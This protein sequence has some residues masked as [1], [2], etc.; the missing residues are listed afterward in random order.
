VIEQLLRLLHHCGMPRTDADLI[1]GNGRVVNELLLRAQPR[2]TLF[3]GSQRVAEKLAV[4]MRGKVGDS[5]HCTLHRA[6]P[7]SYV[8]ALPA[9]LC[10]VR[11]SLTRAYKFVTCNTIHSVCSGDEQRKTEGR[12]LLMLCRRTLFWH[13]SKGG[14]LASTGKC[15][16][17]ARGLDVSLIIACYDC[18]TPSLE[19]LLAMTGTILLHAHQLQRPLI[20]A[21]YGCLGRLVK[22]S[23]RSLHAAAGFL[24]G[25]WL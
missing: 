22:Q 25:C 3:T 14:T 4:D 12:A 21:T 18:R 8:L 7:R 19:E 13:V 11:C 5:L 6:Y 1:H 16:L 9:A 17:Q 10:L 2:S 23:R 15:L 24:G 20:L